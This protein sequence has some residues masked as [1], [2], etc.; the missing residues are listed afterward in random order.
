MKSLDFS[1]DLILTEASLSPASIFP[2]TGV[3]SQ[4]TESTTAIGEHGN[5]DQISLISLT[6]NSGRGSQSVADY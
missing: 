6:G 4:Y 1:I 2:L 5:P 3:M